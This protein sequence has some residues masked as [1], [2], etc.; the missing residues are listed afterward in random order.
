MFLSWRRLGIVFACAVVVTLAVTA[1]ATPFAPA[2]YASVVGAAVGSTV[3]LL[4]VAT[5]W[6]WIL[7]R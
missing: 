4:V 6:G 2:E 7:R 5:C 3:G 1:I